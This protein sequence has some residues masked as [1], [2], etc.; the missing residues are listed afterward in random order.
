MLAYAE[1]VSTILTAYN[2]PCLTLIAKWIPEIDS[3]CTSTAKTNL[4]RKFMR[5]FILALISIALYRVTGRTV[6]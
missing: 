2:S 3:A 5:T 6:V 4:N 1:I